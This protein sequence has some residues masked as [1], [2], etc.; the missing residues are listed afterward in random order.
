MSLTIDFTT[1]SAANIVHIDYAKSVDFQIL[2][3]R[4][5]AGL[6]NIAISNTG[7][8]PLCDL[9]PNSQNYI[10]GTCIS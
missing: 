7:P 9:S 3:A 5:I 8:I 1:V 10:F 6:M 2:Y 4:L